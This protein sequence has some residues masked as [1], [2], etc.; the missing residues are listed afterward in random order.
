MGDRA[1]IHIFSKDAVVEEQPYGLGGIWFYT[2]YHGEELPK[3]LQDALIRGRDIWDD[4][5]YLN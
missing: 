1:N 4:E 5:P 2:H 3:Y